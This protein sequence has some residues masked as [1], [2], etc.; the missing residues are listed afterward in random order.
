MSM[1][2]QKGSITMF[3]TP[4]HSNSESHY[5]TCSILLFYENMHALVRIHIAYLHLRDLFCKGQV[6]NR[7][8]FFRRILLSH[9]SLVIMKERNLQKNNTRFSMVLGFLRNKTLTF[10]LPKIN[11]ATKWVLLN[12]LFNNTFLNTY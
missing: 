10:F 5:V 4:N 8:E 9:I 1:T 7:C 12:S 11:K 3:S 6:V 2:R